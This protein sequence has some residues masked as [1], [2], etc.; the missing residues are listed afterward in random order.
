MGEYNLKYLS[1]IG[2]GK[3]GEVFLINERRCIKKYRKKKYGFMEF[4]ALEKGKSF[5]QFPKV[6]SFN[7]KFMER[8][9]CP[10][11]D[12]REYIKRYGLNTKL[13]L[14][15]IKIL[16][17]F[18]LLGF[19]RIDCR[20][21]HIIVQKDLNLKIIDPTR[22]MHKRVDYPRQMLQELDSLGYKETFLKTVKK[23][24]PDFYQKWIIRD[25]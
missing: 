21:P 8:E 13:A 15:L 12:A 11:I 19:S 16:E 24:R 18:S 3:H 7:G 2:E 10:G 1:K 17:V 4:E 5:P 9:Y 22:N 20:L 25:S 6:Y 14:N 23:V